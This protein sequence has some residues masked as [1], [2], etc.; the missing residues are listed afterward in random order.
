VADA[1]ALARQAGATRLEVDANRHA[2]DFYREVGFVEDGEVA[3]EHGTAL[4]MGMDL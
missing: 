1:V 2:L 4:R 3:L